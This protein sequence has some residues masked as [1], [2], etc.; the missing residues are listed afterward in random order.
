M[1]GYFPHCGWRLMS[2]AYEVFIRLGLCIFD[3]D[4]ICQARSNKAAMAKREFSCMINHAFNHHP[5]TGGGG[6][7]TIFGVHA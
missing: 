2:N 3:F 1:D 6:C 5:G 4:R 7:E